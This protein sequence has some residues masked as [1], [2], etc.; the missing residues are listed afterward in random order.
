M[1]RSCRRISFSRRSR[2]SSAA[3][4]LAAADGSTACR[5]RLRPSQRTNV[6]SPIPRSPAISRWVRPLVCARRTASSSNSFVNRRCCVIEFLFAHRELS[7]FPK[8]VQELEQETEPE[9]ALE[10]EQEGQSQNQNPNGQSSPM[11]RQSF[12]AR[13]KGRRSNGPRR[14]ARRRPRRLPPS[15]PK[16]SGRARPSSPRSSPIRRSARCSSPALQAARGRARSRSPPRAGAAR[17]SLRCV[18][19]DV[20]VTPSEVLGGRER[21]GLG[22]LLAGE[23]ASARSSAATRGRACI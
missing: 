8:Q 2:L 21:P 19:I 23:A 12:S 11:R 10:P 4:S 16:G 20:G 6:D 22:D 13:S 5:S 1:S 18:L 9:L 3:T 17:E 7:T 14:R 15:L